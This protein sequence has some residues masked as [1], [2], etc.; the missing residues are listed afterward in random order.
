[1]N[2]AVK[3]L[4]PDPDFSPE[5]DYENLE[6]HEL[7]N[8]YPLIEGD[9]FDRLAEDIGKKGILRPIDIFE[10]KILEGRNRYNAAKAVRRKL[11]ARD[12]KTFFGSYEDA[13]E[14][15]S[16]MN[17]HRRHLDTQQKRALIE[18]K[19][20]RHPGRNDPQIAKLVGC[21]KKTIKSV[22]EDMAKRVEALTKDWN[23]LSPL[24]RQQFVDGKREEIFAALGISPA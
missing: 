21:D 12:F 16:S 4:S 10:G 11:T 23:G 14:Y 7:A 22:R 24:Q 5:P 8:E 19:I 15:V 6:F 2:D 17:G 9:D 18:K 1:M 13:E 20:N 3:K